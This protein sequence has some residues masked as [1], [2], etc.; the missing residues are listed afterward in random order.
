VSGDGRSSRIAALG[1]D[2][3]AGP[4]EHVR[5]C[6]LCGCEHLVEVARRDRYGYP[7][8]LLACARCGLGFLS[9]RPTHEAYGAFY[10]DVYRPLVSAYHGRRIDAETVQ[11]EQRAYAAELAAFVRGVT[12]REPRSVLDVG[13][14]TGIVAA[15]FAGDDTTLTVLDP[16][17]DELAVAAAAGMATVEGFAEDFDPGSRRWELVL[18]CQTI[19]HLLDVGGTLRALRGL[20]ADG[21]HAFVDVLDVSW[22]LARTGAIEDSYKIDHPFY[23]TRLTARAYFARTG[24]DVV[25]ERM[26][27]DGHWGFVLAGG[28]EGELDLDAMQ[29]HADAFLD[30]AWRRRAEGR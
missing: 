23:L 1:Y 24:F 10:T 3:A 8:T 26:A 12:G 16:A 14:S 11:A 30:E 18:L 4:R 19:D 5:A 13:G 7:T 22:V 21:G 15:A 27:D 2:A 25:A 20:L 17:P 29:Q 9:P 28:R 6:N